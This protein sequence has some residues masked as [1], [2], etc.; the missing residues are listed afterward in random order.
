MLPVSWKDLIFGRSLSPLSS[1]KLN[2]PPD[3]KVVFAAIC[4]G[5]NTAGELRRFTLSEPVREAQSLI[6]CFS[7]QTRKAAR[8]SAFVR[9]RV[10]AAAAVPSLSV[11]D[12]EWELR[13]RA[14]GRLAVLDL[15][16]RLAV[17]SATE[18]FAL[19]IIIIII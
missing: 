15:R 18:A 2:E 14:R 13:V 6:R 7:S 5:S 8:R 11:A 10:P 12:E 3:A 17:G 9:V 19:L 1:L 4:Y 16:T